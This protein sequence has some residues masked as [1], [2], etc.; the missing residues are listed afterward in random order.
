MNKLDYQDSRRVRLEGRRAAW[1]GRIRLSRF[2]A[3]GP[4]FLEFDKA[5]LLGFDEVAAAPH[6]AW[7]EL[8]GPG[9]ALRQ[10]HQVR[11]TVPARR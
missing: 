5:W 7:F 3:L 6:I 1:D 2:R 4:D 8:V 11:R 10:P 9:M